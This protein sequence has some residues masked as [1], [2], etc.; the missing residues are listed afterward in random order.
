MKSRKTA[1]RIKRKIIGIE[2][3]FI[4]MLRA[5]IIK[6]RLIYAPR[7]HMEYAR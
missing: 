3:K 6:R 7:S 4:W 2:L 1:N 5:H